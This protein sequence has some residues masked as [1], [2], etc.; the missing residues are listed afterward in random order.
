MTIQAA[1]RETIPAPSRGEDTR[2]RLIEAA[3]EIFAAYGFEGASTRM[4]ADRAGANLAAIPYHF[5]SKEGLYL[6]AAHSIVE[7]AESEMSPVI[8]K[9]ERALAQRK[10]D[11]DAA[12]ALL[13]ELLERFSALVIGSPQADSWSR[14]VLREQL[15]PGAAFEIIFEGIMRKNARA[16]TKL[17]AI[18]LKRPEGDPRVAVRAQTILGEILVFHSSG[19]AALRLLGWKEFSAARLKVIQAILR[20]NVDRI[21]A[22]VK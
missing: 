16:F 11:R 20:E 3:L 12:A 2:Q 7:A 17:L 8:G 6:A 21:V 1:K 18:L 13:H 5:G 19:T 22:P 14:F 15:Q 9:I 10:L 4:L